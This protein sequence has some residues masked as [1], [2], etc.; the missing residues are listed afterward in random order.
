MTDYLDQLVHLAQVRGEVNIRCLFQGQWQ[1]EHQGNNDT[2]GLF[3]L[4]EAGECWLELHGQSFHLTQGDVFFLSQNQPH[5]MR[6][7]Q[8]QGENSPLKTRAEGNFELHQIGR[9]SP[10][11]KM[12]CGAFYYQKEALLTASLPTYLHLNLRDTPIQPLI[13]LFLTEAEHHEAGSKS[14]IDA[15]AQVLFIY[16][17]RHGIQQGKIERGILRALQD[18]RLHRVLIQLLHAPEDTWHIEQL[19]E[20]AAMSR[21]HFSRVFQQELG[22]SPGKFLTKVRLQKA[23]FL[24]KQ[25]QQSVLAIA[26][27]VGYQSEAHF[28]KSFKLAYGHSPRQYRKQAD[29]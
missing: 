1:V 25:S 3:H 17:L 19:A 8:T 26:L 18:K 6:A 28:S 14:V 5:F 20:L 16:M 27:E 7:T 4:I 22:M 2:Q 9:G 15:L 29:K 12:F 13:Q 24:L 10:N 11:L 21:A 23:A